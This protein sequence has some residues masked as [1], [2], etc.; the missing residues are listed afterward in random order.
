MITVVCVK[1]GNKYGAAHVNK[2]QHMVEQCLTVPHEFVCMTERPQGVNCKTVPFSNDSHEGWW[3]KMNLFNEDSFNDW[4]LYF[5]LDVVI[6]SNIDC[7]VEKRDKNFYSIR[8]FHYPDTFN[9]S[10][11]FWKKDVY[12]NLYN[13]FSEDSHRL[14]GLYKGDQDLISELVKTG[15]DWATYPDEWTWSWR[16]GDHRNNLPPKQKQFQLSKDAKVAVF[17]GRPN[18]WEIDMSDFNSTVYNLKKP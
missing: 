6:H 7:L 13:I 17:H 5:D 15:D 18:P 11:M 14:I 3:A 16:W 9:S 4:V 2:L 8:D 10:I 1:W 12:K